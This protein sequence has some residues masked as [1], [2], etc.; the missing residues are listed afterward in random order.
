[1]GPRMDS[2]PFGL[3]GSALLASAPILWLLAGLGLLRVPAWRACLGGLAATALIAALG[4]R[5]APLQV[6]RAALE[7]ALLGLWPILAVIFA[8]IFT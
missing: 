2:S 4:W 1:M 3:V 5:M 8:A 7:G 6:A